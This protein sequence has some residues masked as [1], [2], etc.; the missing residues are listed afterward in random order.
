[1]LT[2][3]E[4]I[5]ALAAGV[6]IADAD[7]VTTHVNPA[8]CRMLER[9]LAACVG[10]PVPLLLGLS[11]SLRD[12]GL[13]GTAA[14][15]RFGL[16][17]PGGR[18]GATLHGVAGRGFV[19]L[20][21][22]AEAGRGADP[23]LQESE[24]AS[25]LSAT[26]AAFAHA[27]RNPLA[28]LA[29][30]VEILRGELA[31]GVGEIQLAIIERQ[32]RRLAAMARAPVALGLPSAV[33]RVRCEVGRLIERSIAALATE[34]ARAQVEVAITVAAG[35]PRVEV[36]EHEIVDALVE[37]IENAIHA[38]APRGRVE[39][40]AQ[41]AN[42]GWVHVAIV[43]DGPGMS[44]GEVAEALRA[45]STTKL[46][47]TGSGLTLAHRRILDCGGRLALEAGPGR[48]LVARIELP[49][50]VGT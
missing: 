14:E 10:Q 21:R 45:F 27:V 42:D 35:L 30:A 16:T 32:L 50:E 43:D 46:G 26:V 29:A 38:S 22:W 6:V 36:G 18:A 41:A 9:E 25:A 20:F 13:D 15:R 48:G 4:V 1:M 5:D 37:L 47:A 24:R 2:D 8:A 39:V 44:P 11:A 17:L 34:L 49:V 19:C 3:R 33:Q 23:Y 40:R 7:E 31:P 12:H 28:S